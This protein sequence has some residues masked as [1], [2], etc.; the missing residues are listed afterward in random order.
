M[1]KI[2]PINP[3]LLF[4]RIRLATVKSEISLNETLH[5]SGLV[6]NLCPDA[7]PLPWH[8]IELSPSH[9]GASS[10]VPV[11]LI[12]S[13]KDIR[14]KDE[15]GTPEVVPRKCPVASQPMG[16]ICDMHS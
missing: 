3:C 16:K 15:K 14:K 6:V 8:S 10:S 5:F 13:L 2:S 9:L 12:A 7:L 4:I 11:R 1:Q